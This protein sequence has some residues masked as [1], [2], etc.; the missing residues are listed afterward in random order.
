MTFSWLFESLIHILLIS[1]WT[2]AIKSVCSFIF[3]K[4]SSSKFINNRRAF[5]KYSL[6]VIWF[7]FFNR[8]FNSLFYGKD[9]LIHIFYCIL[10]KCHSHCFMLIQTTK[11]RFLLCLWAKFRLEL[12]IIVGE[13]VGIW[14]CL[15]GSLAKLTFLHVTSDRWA[16]FVN[17]NTRFSRFDFDDGRWGFSSRAISLEQGGDVEGVVSVTVWVEAADGSLVRRCL[18]YA[19]RTHE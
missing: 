19:W 14:L 17:H 10:L 8:L 11:V 2:F 5:F 12:V 9:W 3:L 4:Y 6:N 16:L 7:S 18:P 1:K 13:T 15:V